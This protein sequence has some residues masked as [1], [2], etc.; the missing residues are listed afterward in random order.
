MIER[1][2]SFH[3]FWP[4]FKPED[5]L[6]RFPFLARKYR[7]VHDQAH[8]EIQIFSV[9]SD[10]R[11]GVPAKVPVMPL[12]P[13][14]GVRS[15]F[16]TGEDVAAEL[17][18]CDYAITFNPHAD[19]VRELRIP[20]WVSRLYQAGF[21]PRSLLQEN[22]R[23]QFTREKFCAFIYRM[24]YPHRERLFSI[25]NARR[26]VDAP[27]NSMNNCRGIGSGIPEKL[28]FLQQYRFNIACENVRNDGYTTEKIVESYLAG[29]IPI[30]HGDHL[31]GDDFNPA[32][33]IAPDEFASEGDFVEALLSIDADV[34]RRREM[35]QAP[36]YRADRIPDCG[37]EDAMM[38]FF[39]RVFA[40]PTYSG[41]LAERQLPPREHDLPGSIADEIGRYRKETAKLG[42]HGDQG[43]LRVVSETLAGAAAFVETGSNVGITAEFVARHFPHLNVYSCEPTDAIEAAQRRCQGYSSVQLV[44]QGSPQFLY[45]L[46]A[47]HPELRELEVTFWL[48]AHAA[49][50]PLPL[51][52]EIAFISKT[53][54]RAHVFIDDCRVPGQAQFQFT[55]YPEATIEA[56]YIIQAL[57]RNREVYV[58]WPKYRARSSRHHPLVGWLYLGIGVEAPSWYGPLY[59]LHQLPA[60]PGGSRRRGEI[61]KAA[62]LDMLPDARTV[63]DCGAHAG[64]DTSE[65]ARL[66]PAATIHAI[67]PAAEI[68]RQ[69][70]INTFRHPNVVR[71]P[72]CIGIADGVGELHVSG[73]SS[74]ASSSLLAPTGHLQAHPGVTFERVEP[75]EMMTFDSWAD[76]QGIDLVDLMWLDMQ[77]MEI[78][79]LTAS[80]QLL[81]RTRAIYT[82]VMTTEL[83]ARA[84][85]FDEARDWLQ[86]RGFALVWHDL[87]FANGGN[88][89]FLNQNLADSRRASR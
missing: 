42:F 85:L 87:A 77:G 71:H 15:L 36:A 23:H 27:G 50:V 35:Q 73:G 39:D 30:Y 19:K 6:A 26:P 82:E 54:S 11:A 31:I 53:F 5:F 65:L 64:T 17:Q 66:W 81:S 7:L 84:T 14:R 47:Q 52:D 2:V 4:N 9:F 22:R 29:C 45:D 61:D 78:N 75:T 57:D 79:C 8:P 24:A 44:R 60:L 70:V 86:S 34:S 89:L 32:S 33:F 56:P 55:A 25:I 1:R 21:S 69:L 41:Q 13:L 63:I 72:V 83:Y 68:Y 38:A 59:D 58:A 76:A 10:H 37:N 40:A 43:L 3:Y 46:V 67:E 88:A 20:N 62:L 16:I 12:P 51:A 80:P 18:H 28:A 49:G 74:N 48:D